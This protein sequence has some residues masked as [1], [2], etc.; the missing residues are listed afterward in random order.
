VAGLLKQLRDPVAGEAPIQHENHVFSSRRE[1]S[2]FIAF[3]SLM[4][5]GAGV[6]EK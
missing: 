1:T 2:L 4:E 5:P 6:R 3:T